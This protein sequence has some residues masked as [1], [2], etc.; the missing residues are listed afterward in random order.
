[1]KKITQKEIAKRVGVSQTT[2]SLVLN[3]NDSIKISDDVK[4]KILKIVNETGYWKNKRR[5]NTG[6]IAYFVPSYATLPTSDPYF[7]RFYA[8]ILDVIREKKINLVLYHLKEEELLF[9]RE[10]F[11]NVDGIIIEEMI[12]DEI[13]ERLKEIKPIVFLNYTSDISVDSVMPDNKGGIIKAVEYL[14]EKGHTRIG[15][16]GMKPFKI[17]QEERFEGYKNGLKIFGLDYR[18]EY[19]FLP[20]RKIGGYEELDNYSKETI[21]KLIN[22]KER[23]TAIIT[24]GDVYALS[25]IKQAGK[26]GMKLPEDL[27]IIGF[28][29]TN[30][31]ELVHPTLTSVNQPME[32]MGKRAVELLIDR[33]NN[34]F[35]KVEKIRFE[36]EI[37]KRESVFEIKRR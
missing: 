6:Q 12:E 34:P 19:V 37:V 4:N 24:L 9:R 7:Y 13:I 11:E 8:G 1:M 31:C 2:V 35:K 21:K 29:N 5:S 36:V 16:Y 27:S 33:I 23:P 28:D 14:Y 18:D 15:F 30:Q 32:D 26:L 22:L 10:I 3:G 17:H 25:L 20:E